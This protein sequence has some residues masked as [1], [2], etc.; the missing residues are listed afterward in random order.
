MSDPKDPK[1]YHDRNLTRFPPRSSPLQSLLRNPGLA[2]TPDTRLWWPSYHAR[3]SSNLF[4]GSDFFYGSGETFQYRT[5]L[6]TVPSTYHYITG[7]VYFGHATEGAPHCVHGGA[8]GTALDQLLAIAVHSDPTNKHVP[9]M[10][11]QLNLEYRRPVPVAEVLGFWC[12]ITQREGRKVFVDGCLFDTRD[13]DLK[14]FDFAGGVP[15]E[16]RRVHST[17]VFCRVGQVVS[18]NDADPD[19]ADE[20]EQQEN[21]EMDKRDRGLNN[22]LQSKL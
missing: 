3:T 13:V 19:A 2:F 6:P 17:A 22:Q 20:E 21:E 1:H 15:K 8:I 9:H 18:V 5:F 14:T 12:G 10:T 4:I 7:L 11:A 16:F